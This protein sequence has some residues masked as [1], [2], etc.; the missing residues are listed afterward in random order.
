MIFMKNRMVSICISIFPVIYCSDF[1]NARKI[2]VNPITE[3]IEK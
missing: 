2:N 1:T 3:E